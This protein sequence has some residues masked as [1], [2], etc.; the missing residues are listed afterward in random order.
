MHTATRDRMR[1]N[2]RK[3]LRQKEAVALASF[4]EGLQVKHFGEWYPDSVFQIGRCLVKLGRWN[5]VDFYLGDQVN[6]YTHTA[7]ARFRVVSAAQ[8]H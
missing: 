7:E 2:W 3:I 5:R 8:S 1:N 4:E 6:A